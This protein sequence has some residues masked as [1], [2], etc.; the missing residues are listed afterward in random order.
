ME[1]TLLI[2]PRSSITIFM[3][4]PR[5]HIWVVDK[6]IIIFSSLSNK[7][8]IQTNISSKNIN[9]AIIYSIIKDITESKL[10]KKGLPTET[11]DYMKNARD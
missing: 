10:R 6:I 5:R 1:T 9:A 4:V 7:T 11:S 3:V 8:H 2:T